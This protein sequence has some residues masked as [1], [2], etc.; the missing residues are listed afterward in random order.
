MDSCNVCVHSQGV[1]SL[2]DVITF[3]D[4]LSD[5]HLKALRNVLCPTVFNV[6]LAEK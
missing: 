1:H 5:E 6:L 4:N 3:V 2:L